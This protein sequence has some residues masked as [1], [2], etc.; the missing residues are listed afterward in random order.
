MT[1][2]KGIVV[3]LVGLLVLAALSVFT[4]DEREKALKLQLG[5]VRRADYEPGLHFKLPLFQNIIKFNARIQ[6]LDSEQKP[7]S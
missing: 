4:V 5:E 7:G 1:Q 3:F 2:S 6:T